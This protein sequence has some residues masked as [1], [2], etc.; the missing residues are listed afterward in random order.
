MEA[1]KN[2]QHATDLNQAYQNFSAAAYADSTWW[3][4][5]YQC[6]CNVS[7]MGQIPAAVACWRRALECQMEPLERAKVLCNIGWRLHWMGYTDEALQ[8]T[9][10][11]LDL[12]PKLAHAWVNLSCVQGVSGR[13][14]DSI[15]SART[16]YE[17]DPK[18]P[19]NEMAYAF[20]LL[21]G[22]Q[23]KDG[24]R[25]FESR[26]E[27]KLTSYLR[28]PYPRWT[29]EAGKI[30]YLVSDQGLG[31]TLS[32]ARFVRE[33]AKRAKFIHACVQPGLIRA[34]QHAFI[35]IKNLDIA[36]LPARL[37]PADC[38]STFMSLPYALGL[39]DAEFRH[40]RQIEIPAYSV[41]S[42]WRVQD[43]KFH[44]GIAW[45]GSPLMEMN[46]HR[47]FPIHHFLELYRVP[48]I[49]LYSFQI[50]DARRQLGDTGCAAVIADIGNYMHDVVDTTAL[51]RQMDL[52]ITC[53]SA[54]GHICA[55]IGKECWIPY[56]YLAH[57]FRI[58]HVDGDRLWCPKHR[59]FW[60]KS[61]MKWEPVFAEIVDALQE[62]VTRLKR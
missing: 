40:A 2:R 16:A 50:D 49:Q 53:E 36:P 7:D 51:L 33:A 29:G 41:P 46:E 18:D 11:S 4:A 15:K 43:R 5:I 26:F 59:I 61:D 24:S 20:A 52:V 42:T 21:F 45:R 17:I 55:A 1:V 56:G 28:Y 19:I 58:G 57:D 27:Y 14:D 8:W 38:W 22:R 25:H 47:S 32:Y 10:A 12:D 34:F 48:G 9:L 3:Q 35:D 6:G 39:G 13:L 60:Q 31:D 44:I 30:V 54:L 37:P 62:K 23:F